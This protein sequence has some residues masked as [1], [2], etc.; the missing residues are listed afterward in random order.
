MVR[1]DLPAVLVVDDDESVC[2]FLETLLVDLGC[3]VQVAES[4]AE[5]LE[6]IQSSPRLDLVLLDKNLPD[7]SG[8]D[9][10]NEAKGHDPDLEVVMITGYAS[11]DAVVMALRFGAGD[12]LTKPF[13]ELPVLTGKIQNALE[14]ARRSRE[15]TCLMADLKA[16]E[17]NLEAEVAQRTRDLKKALSALNSRDMERRKLMA[18]VGHDLRT[19]LTTIQG[20]LEI[21]MGGDVGEERR[22]RHMRKMYS[23]C[24]RLQRL[25]EDVTFLARQA[26]G[27]L[28]LRPR[29]LETK[30]LIQGAVTEME[31]LF[32]QGDIK[33]E[34]KVADGAGRIRGDEDR[35]MQVLT[36]LMSN[37]AKFSPRGG[38]V[39]LSAE[40]K[41]GAVLISLSDDGPGVA[42]N[43]RDVI[44]ERY[45]TG[46]S[47]G[48]GEG[49]GLSICMDVATAHGGRIWV[50][51]SRQGGALFRLLLPGADAAA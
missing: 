39:Q 22:L 1:R 16:R 28:R 47:S 27:R 46:D 6:R 24:Q 10:L 20:Y 37:A 44:F 25:A 13:D 34:W 31:P 29:S 50:E 41:D 17:Q 45:H 3:D 51:E 4:A 35:L 32:E 40:P 42:E 7:R 23:Q 33:V 2:V 36:N 9:V 5:A 26:D 14:R 8:L 48:R 30:E 15:R 49:I 21:L 43:Q 18:N 12:F 19:P 38:R 11:I